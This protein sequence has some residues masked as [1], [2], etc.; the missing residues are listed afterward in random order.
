MQIERWVKVGTLLV[1]AFLAVF[2]IWKFLA[3]QS[4]SNKVLFLRKQLDT[5][6]EVSRIAA[7]LATSCDRSEWKEARKQFWEIYWGPL[8]LLENKKVEAAMVTFG[9]LI[10][11]G[12][13]VALPAIPL[14]SPSYQL[15]LALREMVLQSWGIEA[16]GELLGRRVE[17]SVQE[18]VKSRVGAITV[19]YP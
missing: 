12:P 16:L 2:G 5:A 8:S 3:E 6:L 15:A 11:N 14:Q 4:Q 17:G 7:K 19:C 18:T 1:A 13:D 9:R 10:P